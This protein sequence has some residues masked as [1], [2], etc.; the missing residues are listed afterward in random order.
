MNI[1][2]LTIIYLDIL[3]IFDKVAHRG[4]LEKTESQGT[5]DNIKDWTGDWL[6]DKVQ[7]TV[8]DGVVSTQKLVMS[9]FLRDQCLG[10]SSLHSLSVT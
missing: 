10:Q 4:H 2:R 9:E 7:R 8:L 1:M 6:K 5:A 3:Q